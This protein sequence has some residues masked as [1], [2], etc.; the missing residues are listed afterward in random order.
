MSKPKAARDRLFKMGRPNIRPLVLEEADGI[1]A[2]MGIIW[3]A[4]RMGSFPDLPKDMSQSELTDYFLEYVSG[5]YSAW[6]VEDGNYHYNPDGYGAVGLI[7]A[8]FNGWDM[9]PVFVRF[10]WA[11]KKNVLKMVIAFFQMARYEKGIGVLSVNSNVDQLDFFKKISK[12]YNVIH[13]VGKV[14]RG[15][16]GLDKYMFYGR[17]K[18]FYRAA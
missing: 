11:T 6:I 3:G 16:N 7:V 15:N 14:P 12:R 10:K 18:D 9:E 4:Y 8:N 5:F 17:G 1:G 2:D 13:Y